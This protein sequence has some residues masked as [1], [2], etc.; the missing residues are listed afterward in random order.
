MSD[1]YVI[2]AVIGEG[3][4]G[5]RYAGRYRPSGHPVALEEVPP[6]LLDRRDF[7]ERLAA[8][9]RQAAAITDSHVV[10]LYD[11]VRIGPHL[12]VVTELV[13]A[14]SLVAL[15]GTEP[16]LPL[17]D[18]LLIVDSVLAA[19]QEIHRGGM[20][21]GDVCADVV[22]VTPTGSV[23]LAE[24][25]VAA[26]LAADAQMPAWPAVQPPEG[27]A[28]GA[29]A[30]LYATGALLRE[31][32]SGMRPEDP[33]E[34]SDPGRLGELVRRSLA[35]APEERFSTAAAFRQELESS[36]AAELGSGWQV[37]SDLAARATRPLGPQPPRPRAGRSLTET[38]SAEAA[39]SFAADAA[40]VATTGARE[41]TPTTFAEVPP[42]PPPPPSGAMAHPGGAAQP[43]APFATASGMGPDPFE[44]SP[45]PWGPV[46]G[47]AAGPHV[48]QRPQ[49]A[50]VSRTARRRGGHLALVLVVLLVVLA[51]AVAALLL[52]T[53]GSST[54][55]ASTP[56]RVTDVRLTVQPGNSGGC[57]TTFTFTATGSVSGTGQLSYQWLKSTGT[58]T[59]IY[60]RYTVTI[61][62][63]EGSF[64]FTTP[65]QLTGQATVQST[66]TFQLL[67]P[68]ATSQTRTV[69]YTCTS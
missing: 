5:P 54:P 65:L 8:A 50:P 69:S 47:A 4:M 34:W 32:A 58:S 56:L 67:S 10:A 22:L 1:D 40:D 46:S 7:V 38:P 25:G 33:G 17:A 29:A 21:H 9:G 61:S 15:L 66:V 48:P 57:G 11:L 31:L 26:V 20:A 27:G 55:A 23:R 44:P 51:A 68:P 24:V 52:L 14:R 62:Q 28:P 41:M 2:G 16:K 53:P 43:P 37:Q 45:V 36:A 42:P 59:P 39:P 18:A 64:R 30:D 60:D 19:L 13:R 6:A 63:G 35:R 49:R 12:Y 3:L